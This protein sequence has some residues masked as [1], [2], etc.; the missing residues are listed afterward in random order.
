MVV[1]HVSGEQIRVEIVL[2]F[3]EKQKFHNGID[4]EKGYEK[5]TENLFVAFGVEHKRNSKY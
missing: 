3:L 1:S 2:L 4:K 5:Q